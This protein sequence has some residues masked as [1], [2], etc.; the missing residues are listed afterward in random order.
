VFTPKRQ[1]LLTGAGFSKDFGGYLSLEM[2][3]VIFSQ[4]EIGRHPELRM[5]LLG[6]FNYERAYNAV[7]QGEQFPPEVKSDFS[8]AVKRSYQQMHT[9]FYE[10]GIRIPATGVCNAIV[11]TFAGAGSKERG[12]VFTLNQDLFMER[13]FTNGSHSLYDM[14]IPGVS[15][16]DCFGYR[17]P[18]KQTEEHR[19][20]LPDEDKVRSLEL[21]YWNDPT[22]GHFN[23]LK[24]HGSQWWESAAGSSVMVIGSEKAG[25]IEKE[26]YLRWTHTI[27]DKVLSGPD[28]DLVVIGYGF[29]DVHINAVIA[30][31]I[32]S[33]GLKLHVVSP[34]QPQELHQ[35][36]TRSHE[37]WTIWEGLHG[38]YTCTVQSLYVGHGGD[39]TALGKSLLKKIGL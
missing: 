36:I 31:A 9:A 6:E 2:W 13:F 20:K 28:C 17:L 14:R 7:L 33:F 5:Y 8:T 19:Y 39:L 32:S 18:E 4:P 21:S 22:Y 29:G 3:S 12:F 15:N 35:R 24:L 27:F 38:C 26:P 34:E 10:Q 11:G 1:V 37:G 16:Y 25:L 23:Y 30:R